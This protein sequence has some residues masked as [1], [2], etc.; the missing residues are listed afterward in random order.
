MQEGGR[1]G[2]L[3]IRGN[4]RETAT[5]SAQLFHGWFLVQ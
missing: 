5:E 3:K 4:R 2:K 1:K